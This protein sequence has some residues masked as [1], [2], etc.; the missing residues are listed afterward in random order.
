MMTAHIVYA[1]LDPALPATLSATVI[2]TVIRRRIGFE[3]VLVTDDLA[4]K[5][6]SGAPADLA[7][8]ALAAGCDIALYCSG[9]LAPTEA[10]LRTCPP[11]TPAAHQRLQAGRRAAATRRLTLIPAQLAAERDRLLA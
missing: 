7:G 1:A 6:L 11:L 5:A 2:E 9:D 4:M 10:L 3:G 8:Q